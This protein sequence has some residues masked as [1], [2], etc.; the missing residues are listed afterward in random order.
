MGTK[1][2]IREW[3]DFFFLERMDR[4]LRRTL[5]RLREKK[6]VTQKIPSSSV[7]RRGKLERIIGNVG[8]PPTFLIN[9]I[10]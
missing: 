7:G 9:L 4:L 3:R 2:G 10:N 6:F 1:I 8:K 5:S